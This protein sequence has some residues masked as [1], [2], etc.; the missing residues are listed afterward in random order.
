MGKYKP[1]YMFTDDATKLAAELKKEREAL[2][3]LLGGKGANLNIMMTQGVPVPPGFTVTTEQCIEFMKAG[4][5][6]PAGLD[7]EIDKAVV[8]LE[9]QTGKTLGDPQNPL[10]VSVRSGARDS[11]PGMMD[12]VLNVGMND[13]VAEAMVEMTGNERFV[14]DAY[15]R[16]IMMFGDVVMGVKRHA[17]EECLNEVKQAE[18][19]KE[20][21]QVSAAGLRKVVELEKGVYKKALAKD[22]PQDAREQLWAGVRAVFESWNNDRAVAYRNMNKIPHDWGTAVNVQTMVFGNMGDDSGTGVAFTRDPAT[23]EKA[24]Y[25]DYLQ[26][27]Q[28]EDVV[29]GIRT[30]M[31]ISELEKLNPKVY[32]QFLAICAKLEKHYKNMQDVEFTVERGKLYMLQT[33]NG[34]RTAQAALRIAV[35]L[36]DEKAISPKEAVMLVPPEQLDQVLH[37]QFDPKAKPKAMGKGVPASP[38]AAAGE[39]VF[40]AAEAVKEAEKGNRVVLVR[41]ETSPEDIRGMAAAQGILTQFGGKTSHAAVVGRQ[42][43]KPC[44]VGCSAIEIDYQKK[45]FAIGDQ[46]VKQGDYI[47]IDGATGEVMLG[48]VATSDSPVILAL[49]GNKKAQKDP[50]YVYF[51]RLMTWADENRRLGVRTNA[52]TPEDSALA[53][54]L[55]AEGIGLTRTEHMFF[56]EARILTFRRMILSDTKEERAAVA[57]ELLPYQKKDFLGILKA[58][59]GKPVII[60]LLDPPLHEFLPQSPEAVKEC[61]EATGKSVKEI[62]DKA[63][64]L[65]ELNPMLGHRGCRL[66][67]TFPEIYEMQ[68]RAIFEAACDLKKKGLNPIPEVMIPLVSLLGELEICFEYTNRVAKEV[69]AA[70]K[71]EVE[72]M[73]GTMIELPRA[74]VIADDIA[75]I[76]QFVSFGT[77]DLT[78][79]AFGFSRDDVEGK[80]FPSYVE[81][82]IFQVSPFETLDVI[83]VGALVELACRKGRATNA[84]L[85]IGI[86]GEHGGDPKSVEFC[87]KV[88]MDYVSCSPLRVPIARL[89]AAQANIQ[90]A[91]A[92]GE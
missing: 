18:G 53:I 1:V 11:M 64:S 51:S 37:P 33:R 47:S 70:K 36:V 40:L 4:N 5:K 24:M 42:M 86:C 30:P 76:A 9:K 80:F 22:F 45:Q 34:K 26:N 69:M 79:T 29:A 57:K 68:V 44:V 43:G 62:Q 81:Q 72:Y 66:G 8:E 78:Q 49:K 41:H 38:G 21:T 74:C 15:R 92:V 27:A 35:D 77:N 19:V 82:R 91:G 2:K 32:K 61:A 23:G 14:F 65:H 50:L 63:A 55:G 89:A 58:M 28:G 46:V 52:D 83:G 56:D 59:D 25:G 84:K 54:A 3:N 16:L 17:F 71:I 20:D 85:E 31:H 10:L 75:K 88:G 39:V 7:K 6:M 12:T 73:I 90:V 13:Q 60:R 87:H 67:V 48:D